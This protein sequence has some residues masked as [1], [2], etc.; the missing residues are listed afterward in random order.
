MENLN[1]Y[2]AETQNLR[3]SWNTFPQ[4]KIDKERFIVPLGFHYTPLKPN[5]NLQLL[6]YEPILCSNCQSILNPYCFL[7]FKSK[8]WECM[9]CMRKNLFPGHYAQHINETTLPPE[10]M[11]E[12]TTVEYKLDKKGLANHPVIF[13]II[14]TS[15]DSDELL[16][17]K[18]KILS[19]IENLPDDCQIGI[20]TFGTMAYLLEIGF[21][22]FP[23][24]HVFRGDKEYSAQEIQELLLVSNSNDP[25]KKGGNS[26]QAGKKF[27]QNKQDCTFTISTFID[28]L[29]VDSFPNLNGQR[30]RNCGGLAL[31]IAVSLLETICNGDP[32]RIELFLGNPPNIGLGKIASTELSETIRNFMDFQ[33]STP[34]IKYF[35]SA[36]DFYQNI[37]TRAYKAG[38]IID[39]FGCSFNQVGLTEMKS[40]VERT[41]GYLCISDSF[42]TPQF[43]DSF[44]KLFDLDDNN[45]L[46]MNFRGK[47]DI[48]I[49][50]PYTIQGGIGYMTSV[51]VKNQKTLD[52][53]S[54]DSIAQGNTR[55]WNIGGLNSNSTYTILI[56]VNT[57]NTS[58]NYKRAVCQIITS[59]IAGDRTYR[60]RVTTFRRKT[61]GEFNSSILEIAQSFDQEAA[62]VMLAKYCVEIGYKQENLETLRWLDKTIIRLVT[63]F[64]EYKK[65]DIHSFKL[66]NKFS[67][68]PQFMYYLR[69]SPFIS[70]FNSS[71]DES[72][73]Y[74]T[75]LLME[76][77]VNCTIMIQPILYSFSAEVPEATP[78]HLD[79]ECMKDDVVLFMDAFFFICVWHG[80]TV[81]GWR[82]KGMQD[83]PEYENVKNML[84]CP[85]DY[86]Q[87]LLMERLP[88]PKFINCDANSGQE[89]YIKFIVNPS[90]GDSEQNSG[91]PDGYYTDDVSLKKF[92]EHLKKKVVQ[93]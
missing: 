28:E 31:H 52:M 33:K 36:V 89:R 18:E 41:G 9:F 91:I 15:L 32:C 64:S 6:E 38:Q 74:K 61:V 34:S 43:K 7:D 65:D 72:I 56:D 47:M 13:F 51:D 84:E 35:K 45:E 57:D 23:K 14:D 54:K 25:L 39:I 40:C 78:V 80:S 50:K 44:S 5:D 83:D 85:L 42:E 79:I 4:S 81:C 75:S 16:S 86:A 63:K 77:L 62:T 21:T 46:K 73:F 82:E 2:L 67:M 30:K 27:L 93:T 20:I 53:I 68:F 11:N 29:Q 87:D 48:Y 59:Y 69:R 70:D 37:A 49:T 12:N 66:N 71:L 24:M 55:V 88:V 19:V 58:Y 22:D 17:L 92:W 10:V 76:N 1:D 8:A 26:K 60:M 90:C 3:C